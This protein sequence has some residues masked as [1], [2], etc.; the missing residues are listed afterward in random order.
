MIM[1]KALTMVAIVAVAALAGGAAAGQT[2]QSGEETLDFGTEG[3]AFP[4]VVTVNGHTPRT[5]QLLGE[6]YR[7]REPVVSKRVNYIADLGQVALPAAAPYLAEAMNDPSPQVRAEA[8]RSAAL[9]G[10]ASLAADVEKLLQ[11]PDAT[12]RREA[13]LSAAALARMHAGSTRAIER[14]LSDQAPQVLAAALQAA[15]TPEHVR[16]IALKL[17]SLPTDLQTEAAVAL[18]RLK[19][20]Q[21]SAAVLPLLKG[22]V[23]QRAAA[24]RA[25][26]EM[27]GAAQAEAALAMLSDPHPTVRREAVTAMGKLADAPTRQARAIQMLGDL[28]L[29]VRQAAAGVLTP[30]PSADAL[31]PLAAQLKEDYASLHEQTRAALVHPADATVRQPT[32]QLAAEMLGDANPRRREDASYIL[33]HLKSDA[34]IDRHVA[35]LQWDPTNPGKTDWLMVAQA[36]E[37]L[38]LIGGDRALEPLMALIKSAPEATRALQRPQRDHMGLA[39]ANA[40]ISAAR[41]HHRP[42]LEQ[43]VRILQIEPVACP[44]RL[45][46]GSAF[47]VGLLAE[48]GGKAPEAAKMLEIYGSI[49]EDRTTKLEAL[50]ALG[51]LRHVTAAERLKTIFESEPRPDLRWIAHW[52]YQRCADTRIPYTPPSERREPPVSISDLAR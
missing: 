14:G 39:M 40:M 48:R 23:V 26:G 43:A 19:S 11:D 12:V 46:A 50:K 25:L 30:V 49:D 22:D 16:Q 10:E 42:A 45:R 2:T 24:V 35:L 44:T 5:A 28:D 51:N 8:A 7:R 31:A 29:T 33:G 34:A 27:A 32:I 52:A 17:P 41:L 20:P 21:Q 47:A 6:A 37:S 4:P 36:A 13:V 18:A 3:L 15:W 1:R 38:G 9:T